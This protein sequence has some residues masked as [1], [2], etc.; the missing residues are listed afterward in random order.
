MILSGCGRIN[1]AD[2]IRPIDLDPTFAF[3][4][5]F[6]STTL[7][8]LLE[9]FDSQALLE[10]DST[11]L[12]SFGYDTTLVIYDGTDFTGLLDFEVP[13][14][15]SLSQLALTPLI[16]Q[17]ITRV[18]FKGGFLTYEVEAPSPGTY[19]LVIEIASLTQ[20]GQK[21]RISRSDTYN[22]SLKDSLSLDAYELF[23]PDEEIELR[24][25]L[26]EEGT[27]K[28][29]AP[30]EARIGFKNLD[31]SYFQG[32]SVDFVF[33]RSS[34]NFSAGIF[35]EG[36]GGEIFFKEPSLKMTFRNSFGAPLSFTVNELSGIDNDGDNI[37]LQSSL[38]DDPLILDYPRINEVGQFRTTEASFDRDNSNFAELIRAAPQ[39]LVYDFNSAAFY[40]AN[41]PADPDIFILDTSRL[42][43]GLD[44]DLPLNLRIQEFTFQ[45]T[46]EIDF[47]IPQLIGAEEI[48]LKL[49]TE[50]GIPLTANVQAYFQT[51]NGQVVDSLFEGS[52][53]LLGA[54]R[55]DADG[56][57]LETAVEEFFI[58]LSNERLHRIR[59]A[60]NLR[61]KFSLTTAHQPGGTV[62]LFADSRLDLKLGVKA[63]I[64][65]E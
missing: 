37:S 52:Q 11:G 44:F 63:V 8:D 35:P 58:T 32:R 50:N 49:L 41:S 53:A 28:Y 59:L 1:R 43:V 64:G 46:Q 12:L 14:L 20:N 7:E 38:L 29:I 57:V 60:T 5:A 18:I 56:N 30:Q 2:K 45:D 40:E 54:A 16:R 10:V 42:E 6:T 25:L 9:R 22:S 17:S 15:D 36:L 61:V 34:G 65:I 4:L 33:L 39:E 55:V 21:L 19:T 51:P 26:L 3:P 62:K 13:V 24:F 23:S 47:E 31:F 48:E 27:G